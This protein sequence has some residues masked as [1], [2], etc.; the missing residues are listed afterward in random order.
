MFRANKRSIERGLSERL[1]PTACW[2]F[3]ETRSWCP[4]CFP[5]SEFYHV[6][7]HV[8]QVDREVAHTNA[9]NDWAK[10]N[11]DGGRYMSYDLFVGSIFELASKS[12][13]ALR[14]PTGSVDSRP[15]G[16][17]TVPEEGN[18]HLV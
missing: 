12:A 13:C 9:C 16:E 4:C 8:C 1:H 10:D 17:K 3:N 18:S 5:R 6:G 11:T 2:Y 14:T 15:T 7:H